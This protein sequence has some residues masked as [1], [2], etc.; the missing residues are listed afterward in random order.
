MKNIILF[1]FVAFFAYFILRFFVFILN[2][3]KDPGIHIVRSFFY[4][5]FGI[6]TYFL[7][8]SE[9][10][11]LNKSVVYYAIAVA[12][13]ESVDSY[14]MYFQEKGLGVKYFYNTSFF[15][16]F[17]LLYFVIIGVAIWLYVFFQ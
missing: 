10:P 5:G 7:I 17:S 13:L 3:N 12:L 6:A 11:D 8:G 15:I 1:P 2:G 9:D 14:F 4:L 16:L